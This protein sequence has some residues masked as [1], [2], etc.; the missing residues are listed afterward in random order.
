VTL[1]YRSLFEIPDAVDGIVLARSHFRS[2]LQSKRDDSRSAIRTCDWDGP[3]VHDLGDSVRVTEVGVSEQDGSRLLRLTLDEATESGRWVTEV[4]AA[5]RPGRGA[6]SRFIWVETSNVADSHTDGPS[7]DPMPPRLIRSLLGEVQGRNGTARLSAR[8]EIVRGNDPEAVAELIAVLRDS[9]RAVPIVVGAGFD[10][11]PLG[12][13]IDVVDKLTRFGI[14]LLSAVVLDG[15]ASAALNDHLGEPHSIPVGGVRT[16]LPAV[17]PGDE[18]DAYRHRYITPSTMADVV[19]LNTAGSVVVRS[20]L[21]H[22]VAWNARRTVLDAGLPSR[23]RRVDVLLRREHTR[24]IAAEPVGQR[25]AALMP[26]EDAAEVAKPPMQV[27]KSQPAVVSDTTALAEPVIASLLRLAEVVMDIFGTEEIS[28]DHVVKF[29]Q[30]VSAMARDVPALEAEVAM[31]DELLSTASAETRRL[32]SQLNEAELA[33]AISEAAHRDLERKVLWYEKQLREAQRYEA[34]AVP[35]EPPAP[36]DL[37]ELMDRLA[38]ESH[39]GRHP[40]L[41]HVVF[42]GDRNASEELLRYDTLGRIAGAAWDVLLTLGDYA[43][44][45]KNEES[46]PR[47]LFE[48]LEAT[49]AGRRAVSRQRYAATE[50]ESVGNNPQWRAERTFLV[51]THID[52]SGSIYMATHF[53]L[54]GGDMVSPRLHLHDAVDS[55]GKVYVGYIGRHLSTTQA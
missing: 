27:P 5:E 33:A 40:L 13:W 36:E 47:N 2:W 28:D 8:P 14:G 12:V 53:R 22:A 21:A 43:D 24:L 54:G 32:H 4:T 17:R 50:S 7:R 25:L 20:T 26:P 9:E 35:V 51:P 11:L 37:A 30:L 42:T 46:P 18:A 45:K 55:D 1:N 39:E 6:W 49:P 23:V 41:E 3:G 19:R 16:F 29:S 31:Y 34:L 15:E 52:A 10:Q 48:Y 44:S 38:N